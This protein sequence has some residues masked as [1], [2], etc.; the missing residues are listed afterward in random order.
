MLC[1]IVAAVGAITFFA[2]AAAARGTSA[3]TTR[4]AQGPV[5]APAIT[6]DNFKFTPV[7]L[8]VPAGT[9][10]V[11]SNRD[12]L[13]HTVVER[14]QKFKSKA[15]DTGDSYSFTFSEPGTYEYFCG[16]HPKMVGKVVVETKK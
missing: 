13:P 9:T 10:V 1:K 3:T 8:T 14:N 11:W 5:A 12:D 6:I 7:S 15:L 16:L 2:F 4:S